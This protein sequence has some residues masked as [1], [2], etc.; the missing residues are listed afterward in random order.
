MDAKVIAAWADAVFAA[1]EAD[2]WKECEER[3]K[4]ED[5]L[6]NSDLSEYVDFD[7]PWDGYSD[8][9]PEDNHVDS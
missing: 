2:L 8:P 5:A 1:Y 9:W 6:R 4:R 7:S 3:L